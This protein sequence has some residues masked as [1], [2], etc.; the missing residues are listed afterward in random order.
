MNLPL[1]KDAKVEGK[2][3]LLRLDLDVPLS[4]THRILDDTRLN[5]DLDTLKYLLHRKAYVIVVGH[6]GRPKGR[7]EGLSLKPVV[8]WFCDRVRKEP[9]KTRIGHFDGWT[10]SN[11][12]SILEN[13]RFHEGEEKNDPKFAQQLAGLAEIYVNDSFDT[14]HRDHASVSGVAKL[15]PHFAGL[16]LELEIS[17]LSAILESPKRP[18]CVIVGGAKIE[19][20]LPLIEKMHQFAD[21][22]LV[23]GM[24]AEETKTLLNVQHEK[25]TGRKSALLV[26]ELNENKTDITDNTVENFVQIIGLC[27]SVIWNGPL[28]IIENSEFKT[29]EARAR[30]ADSGTQKIAEAII[31][32]KMYALAGGGD[33]V[34]FLKS[35]NLLDSFHLSTGG[36]AML[37]FLAGQKLPGI[38]ALLH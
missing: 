23:A 29:Q 22:V 2:T 5:V 15:L 16:R 24:L 38:E 14:S 27:K 12:L 34:G 37:T 33:T 10:L 32:Y 21:Y 3:V 4:K 30:E 7:E 25:V 26:A 6:L 28:G 20:K 11:N 1:L 13:I 18:L 8:D 17:E 9:A 36:G 19:T 35:N 31:K